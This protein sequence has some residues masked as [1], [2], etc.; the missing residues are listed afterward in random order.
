MINTVLF[1]AYAT[2]RVAEQ[3]EIALKTVFVFAAIIVLRIYISYST[4]LIKLY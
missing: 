1:A 2:R 4:I 3:K